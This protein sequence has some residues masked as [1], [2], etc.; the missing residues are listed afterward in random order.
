M[1]VGAQC[2]QIL[3]EVRVSA[4]VQRD[5]VI[6]FQPAG[7][8]TTNAA[9]SVTLEYAQP[10]QLPA[11]SVEL[12]EVATTR[13]FARHGHPLVKVGREGTLCPLTMSLV[14]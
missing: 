11:L 4:L 5:D 13:V 10:E 3:A 2:L 6:G 1:A 7:L 12:R 8:A 14:M 9:P